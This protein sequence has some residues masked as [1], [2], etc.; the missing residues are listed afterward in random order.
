MRFE[1]V[2]K[3][4]FDMLQ[5]VRLGTIVAVWSDG[6]V[7]AHRDLGFRYRVLPNGQKEEALTTFVSDGFVPSVADIRERIKRA[8]GLVTAE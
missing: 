5:E 7:S 3:Q 1:R 4:V 8:A 2:V 6:G